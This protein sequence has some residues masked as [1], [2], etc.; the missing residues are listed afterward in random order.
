MRT[1]VPKI[2]FRYSSIYDELRRE[3]LKQKLPD[4]PS[5]KKILNFKQRVEK[6]WKRKGVKIL[7]ELSKISGLKWE[8]KEIDCYLVGGGIS[9]SDPLTVSISKLSAKE[10]LKT[11]THELI[12]RLFCQRQNR[13]RCKKAWQWIWRRYKKESPITKIHIPLFAIYS[14]FLLKFY[15]KKELK[16]ELRKIK[17]YIWKRKDYLKAW[18]IVQTQGPLK[19]L[20]KFKKRFLE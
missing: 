15:G 9:F 8:E 18:E 7:K 5:P 17:S 4:Y 12:H 19:I 1:R 10:F 3:K 11:L 13:K 20:E 2:I 6:L 16:R 14:L